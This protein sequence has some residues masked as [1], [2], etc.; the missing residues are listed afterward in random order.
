[1][2]FDKKLIN[3]IDKYNPAIS[4]I[5]SDIMFGFKF[6][7]ENRQKYLE[8]H[9]NSLI[10]LFKDFD[11]WMPT[12]NYEF[13]NGQIYNVKDTPTKLGVLNEKFRKENTVWRTS[14][15]VFSFAGTGKFPSI[16]Q[17]S[18]IDPFGDNSC[19]D[20]LYQSEGLLVHYGSQLSSSTIL[21][22]AETI[23]KKISYRYYKSFFG[24]VVDFD[25]KIKD[26]QLNF[27]VRPKDRHLEYDFN[28][29]ESDLLKEDIL[30]IY[31]KDGTKILFLPIREFVNYLIHKIHIDELY[32]LDEYSIEWVSKFLDQIGRPFK[33]T[34]F[35]NE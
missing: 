22:Y 6:P 9:Q 2:I 1:M 29:I 31:K 15:P 32:L 17:S 20:Y 33:L 24:Q 34:D 16:N 14:V 3:L 18:I 27:H 23:S 35:E 5:H 26:V 7:F 10:E 13:C 8:E 30:K 12:F 25:N 11:I 4:L 19:F 28:K 21:H